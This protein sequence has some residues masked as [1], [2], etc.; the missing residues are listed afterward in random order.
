MVIA[1]DFNIYKDYEWPVQLALENS[2]KGHNPCLAHA[3]RYDL[4][5]ASR[6]KDAWLEVSKD[7]GFT[8]SNMVGIY[9]Y[10][11]VFSSESK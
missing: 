5:Y 4:T 6:F 8:F 3:T 2:D 11:C 1:G 9:M 7:D 10:L